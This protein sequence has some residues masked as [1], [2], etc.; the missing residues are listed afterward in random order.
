[1]QCLTVMFLMKIKRCLDLLSLISDKFI[2]SLP[3]VIIGSIV[4]S[5]ILYIPTMLQIGLGLVPPSRDAIENLHDYGLCSTYQETRRFKFSAAVNNG[6]SSAQK[7]R[8]EN[9]LLQ[10]VSDNFN[11]DINIQ[12]GIKQINGI[13]TIVTQIESRF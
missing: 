8:A 2:F 4:D 6:K 10:L 7:L 5:T 1:M 12:N 13:A 11:A 3:T 9:G